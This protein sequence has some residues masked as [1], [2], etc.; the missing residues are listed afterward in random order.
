MSK[1]VKEGQIVTVY[2]E[3]H[4]RGL[5]RLG[6]IEG[7]MKGPDGRIRGARVRVLS[8][9]GRP[10]VLKRPIQHLYPLEVGSQQ[11]DPTN[12][13]PEMALTDLRDDLS[14][15]CRQ[16]DQGTPMDRNEMSQ[17]RRTQRH[18]ALEARDRILGCV[19]D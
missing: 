18:A 3:G 12:A 9:P 13:Q 11:G 15:T 4:P 8:K 16:D 2:D 5:W 6:K 19:T 7:V 17:G 1:G 10:T 14:T